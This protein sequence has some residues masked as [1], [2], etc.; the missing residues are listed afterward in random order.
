MEPESSSNTGGAKIETI[1]SESTSSASASASKETPAPAQLSKREPEGKEA[2]SG[3]V[4]ADGLMD[5]S[6]KVGG[7]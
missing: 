6:E 1:G 4:K 5:K 2:A 7:A 3:A